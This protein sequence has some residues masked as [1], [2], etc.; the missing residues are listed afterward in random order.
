MS[1]TS[2][3]SRPR[4]TGRCRA[5]QQRGAGRLDELAQ[6]L[7]GGLLAGVDPL[8][9]GG[10]LGGDAAAG[11]AGGVPRPDLGQQ[12]LGLRGGQVLLRPARDELEQQVVQLRDH[13]G[14]VLAERPAPVG[15]DAQHSELLV[16][17]DR[18][19]PAMRVPTSATE[20]ASVAS[21][22][23]PWPVENT[24]TR[25]DSF[26][27]TSTTC[28]SSASR[29]VATCRPIRCSPRQPRRAPASA[30]RPAAWRRIRAVGRV[31]ASAEH[32]LVRRH[33]LDGDRPLVLDPC[34]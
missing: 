22:L 13:A 7:V 21:V 12:R 29:R 17:D 26:G 34:R 24:R 9:V 15:Q 25:A 10:E 6:L 14:V 19:R 33:H 3:S 31:P 5:G 23:R 27:G 8:E 1:P 2:M 4:R 11:L 28:S 30:S 20:C 16:V 18:R 32:R